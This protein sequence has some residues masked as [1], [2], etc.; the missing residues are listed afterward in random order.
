MTD[1]VQLSQLYEFP[2]KDKMGVFYSQKIAKPCG[3]ADS[4]IRVPGKLKSVPLASAG[5]FPDVWP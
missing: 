2:G 3:A 5:G 1:I 4:A